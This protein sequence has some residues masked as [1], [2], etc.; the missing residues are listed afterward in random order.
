LDGE[1]RVELEHRGWEELGE[2]AGSA[3]RGYEAGWEEALAQYV[4]EAERRERS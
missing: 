4:R 2:A 3:R 1:T